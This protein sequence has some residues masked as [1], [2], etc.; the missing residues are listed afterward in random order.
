M[1]FFAIHCI[2]LQKWHRFCLRICPRN[3]RGE[4]QLLRITAT[5]IRRIEGDK[6]VSE[7]DAIL[8]S[9]FNF[10]EIGNAKNGIVF[11]YRQDSRPA[12]ASGNHCESPAAA[13]GKDAIGFAY[14]IFNQILRIELAPRRG[15]R[16]N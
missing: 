13:S 6:S 1:P 12:A 10:K 16:Q 5:P 15:E 4:S 11:A 14:F 9:N 8:Q 7:N 3:C 2:G